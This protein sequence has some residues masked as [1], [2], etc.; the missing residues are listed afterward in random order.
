MWVRCALPHGRQV[1]CDGQWKCACARI[2]GGGRKHFSF[3]A[4]IL[5][6]WPHATDAHVQGT[7][8]RCLYNKEPPREHCTPPPPRASTRARHAQTNK[9]KRPVCFLPYVFLH[10][11]KE[12]CLRKKEAAGGT[13]THA[14][15]TGGRCL[16]N[17]QPPTDHCTHA[18]THP[19]HQ[20]NLERPSFG[21]T[22]VFVLNPKQM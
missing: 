11:E 8:G 16:C 6:C 5:C 15:G 10:T 9:S 17:K 22:Y 1:K 21:Y 18:R 4:V 2:S 12:K 14:Q 13:E 7:G 3:Y 19:P 20:M